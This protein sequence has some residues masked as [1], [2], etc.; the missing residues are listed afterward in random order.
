MQDKPVLSRSKSVLYGL[1]N[2]A[3]LLAGLVNLGI[4]TWAAIQ[5]NTAIAGTSLVAGLVLL[6]A[7][8]I[9][10]FESL[11]GL[12]VEAKTRQL[13]QKLSQADEALKRLRETAEIT[14]AALIDLSS[15][16]GRIGTA[17]SARESVALASRVRQIMETLG[18]D[19]SAVAAALSPWARILC[20]DLARALVAPLEQQLMA[21][22]R[23]F[24]ELRRRLPSPI[25][26]DD[27][28]YLR[29]SRTI[30]EVSAFLD[31]R[32]RKLNRL[33]LEDY[34]DRFM[35]LFDEVPHLDPREIEPHRANAARF[36]D[37]M[38]SLRDLQQLPNTEDWIAQIDR[39]RE[40]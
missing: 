30:Q 3:L 17:P 26:A 29:L 24:E 34:P 37:G 5:S 2:W 10:R 21:K 4:G 16:T 33:R 11:K 14:C 32:L 15:K 6:F 28:E 27:P 31:G 1:T 7:A 38:R 9:D 40:Q 23:E 12:G 8:T 20:F 13:D 36:S 19:R 35:M 18:S 39:Q 25:R 22:S